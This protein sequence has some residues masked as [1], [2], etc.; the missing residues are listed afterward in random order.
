MFAIEL[1]TLARQGFTD[2]NASVCLQLVRDRFIAGQA[3]CSLCRHLDSEGP[4][5]RIRDIVDR[6][7]V[8]ESHAEDTDKWGVGRR[9]ERPW[10]VYQV[11]SVDTD[12]KMKDTSEDSNVLGLLFVASGSHFHPDG[13]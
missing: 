3:E 8:W 5:T 4:D 6:C 12:S 13:P 10:V 2:V 11:A 1:E 9:S 7:R